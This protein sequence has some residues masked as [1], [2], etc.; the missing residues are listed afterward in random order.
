MGLVD[1]YMV[2]DRYVMGCDN[3]EELGQYN[4]DDR[5]M[6][7][8]KKRHQYRTLLKRKKIVAISE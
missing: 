7:S 3:V 1:R 2:Y 5:D 6:M 8:M 4:L